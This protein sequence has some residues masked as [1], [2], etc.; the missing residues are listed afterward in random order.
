[1]FSS[2]SAAW[3]S[4]SWLTLDPLA[5]RPRFSSGLPLSN[6][7]VEQI[8]KENTS[9]VLCQARLDSIGRIFG[10]LAIIVTCWTLDPLALRLR[11][12]PDLPVSDI[13]SGIS[14][15]PILGFVLFIPVMLHYRL[16]NHFSVSRVDLKWISS[17]PL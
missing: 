11:L 14:I 2:F 13:S 17:R 7:K 3:Q 12:S 5:L 15:Q 10:S 6:D 9:L 1:M 4:L 8:V 16:V